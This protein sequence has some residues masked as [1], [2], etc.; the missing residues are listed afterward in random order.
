MLFP[1]FFIFL[2]YKQKN[3][4]KLKFFIRLLTEIINEIKRKL[5]KKYKHFEKKKNV[6]N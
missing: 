3:F 4:L 1:F 2:K 5:Y 6:C